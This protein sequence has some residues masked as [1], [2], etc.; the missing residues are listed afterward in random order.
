MLGSSNQSARQSA[1]IP[2]LEGSQR[3]RIVVRAI[4]NAPYTADRQLNPCSQNKLTILDLK[5]L[6]LQVQ[7]P[8]Q[9]GKWDFQYGI[10][11]GGSIVLGGLGVGKRV[12]SQRSID[13]DQ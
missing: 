4:S 8:R 11:G 12:E 3:G 13:R 7:Q 10:G 1:A 9:K 5:R 2:K 6:R